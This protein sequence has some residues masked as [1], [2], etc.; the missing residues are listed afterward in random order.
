MPGDEDFSA[1]GAFDAAFAKL[2]WPLVFA[3]YSSCDD[4]VIVL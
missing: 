2:V 3:F 4:S 1:C